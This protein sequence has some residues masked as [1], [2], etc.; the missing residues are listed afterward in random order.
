MKCF[1]HPTVD[2]VA[3]CK[4]CCRGLCRD[5]IAEVGLSC[6]C[7][8][9]CEEDVAALDYLVERGRTVY[10]KTSYIHF[11]SGVFISLIGASLL[12]L[13]GSLMATGGQPEGGIFWLFMGIIFTGWGISSLISAR[14]MNQK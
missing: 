13:G 12:L 9:R 7:R 5:C 6:S 2:A 11:W 14:K 8:N 10:Q 4:S 3:T 1:N